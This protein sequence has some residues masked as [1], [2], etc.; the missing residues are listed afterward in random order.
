MVPRCSLPLIS[1]WI[2]LI[3][4]TAR[5]EAHGYRSRYFSTQA[6]D[7]TLRGQIVILAGVF[8]NGRIF[9]RIFRSAGVRNMTTRPRVGSN[10][11]VIVV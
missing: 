5:C 2:V 4:A 3:K 1:V 9:G 7:R 8:S 10:G 6:Y 11:A